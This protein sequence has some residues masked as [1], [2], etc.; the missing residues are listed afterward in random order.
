MQHECHGP[1]TAET[2]YT[3]EPLRRRHLVSVSMVTLAVSSGLPI[4]AHRPQLSAEDER[5]ILELLCRWVSSIVDNCSGP[6]TS[7]SAVCWSRSESTEPVTSRHAKDAGA[8]NASD[9]RPKISPNRDMRAVPPRTTQA[10]VGH[11]PQMPRPEAPVA[12]LQPRTF[13]ATSG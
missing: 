8:G 3:G 12:N 10:N 6:L 5:T 7:L 1:P 4:D 2:S 11:L 9:Q 13:S